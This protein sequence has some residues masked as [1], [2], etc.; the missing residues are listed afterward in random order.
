MSKRSQLD[1]R[2]AA[3]LLSC[4]HTRQGV[5]HRPGETLWQYLERL[6]EELDVVVALAGQALQD[7]PLTAL[8]AAEVG[9]GIEVAPDGMVLVSEGE[10]PHEPRALP[11]PDDAPVAPPVKKSK[12]ARK[13]KYKRKA[14]KMHV[15]NAEF[16]LLG[17]DY[18]ST[19]AK[20]RF[21][22]SVVR[23]EAYLREV[24]QSWLDQGRELP[25]GVAPLDGEVAAPAPVTI[26]DPVSPPSPVPA[27]EP[28]VPVTEPEPAPEPPPQEPEPTN[29]EGSFGDLGDLINDSMEGGDAPLPASAGPSLVDL[30]RKRKSSA[31]PVIPHSSRAEE[32]LQQTANFDLEAEIAAFEEKLR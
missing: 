5:E 13:R 27:L 16:D 12:P 30:V 1:S 31:A 9:G 29:G 28:V 14:R 3:A 6:R 19:E 7:N 15:I 24:K 21:G 18:T 32:L 26:S 23:K 11:A 20:A 17:A 10:A 22:R 4:P 2:L 25:P 8:V